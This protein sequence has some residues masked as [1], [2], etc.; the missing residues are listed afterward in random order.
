MPTIHL[1]VDASGYLTSLDVPQMQPPLLSTTLCSTDLIASHGQVIETTLL[2]TQTPQLNSTCDMYLNLT[3][4]ND[5]TFSQSTSIDLCRTSNSIV[6]DFSASNI[7]VD[8]Y[9]RT[10]AVFPPMFLVQYKG[11]VIQ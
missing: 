2:W 4:S 6:L 1:P 10:A 9:V 5:E 3:N 11:E 8:Y 7:T